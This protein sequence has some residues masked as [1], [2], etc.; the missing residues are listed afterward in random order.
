VAFC[1]YDAW[2]GRYATQMKGDRSNRVTWVHLD[3]LSGQRAEWLRRARS[4]GMPQRVEPGKRYPGRICSRPWRTLKGGMM[5]SERVNRSSPS[6][7]RVKTTLGRVLTAVRY[8]SS[9]KLDCVTTAFLNL[10]WNGGVVSDEHLERFVNGDAECVMQRFSLDLNG[11]NCALQLRSCRMVRTLPAAEEGCVV[12]YIV[13][14]DPAHA[15]AVRVFPD[16][17]VHFFPNDPRIGVEVL[18]GEHPHVRAR[19][20][21]RAT[22]YECYRLFLADRPL[23]NRKRRRGKCGRKSPAAGRQ[24]RLRTRRA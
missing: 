4:Q 3:D 5:L 8:Q 9:G 10:V 12:D 23:P 15:D 16:G 22:E 24:S 11:M 21:A 7:L 20:F 13:A 1:G 6:D 17:T 2:S 14:T 18:T 19:L